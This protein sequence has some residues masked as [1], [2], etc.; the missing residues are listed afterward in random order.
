[1]W[2]WRKVRRARN[3]IQI[4]RKQWTNQNNQE[5]GKTIWSELG[6]VKNDNALVAT[7]VKL[8]AHIALVKRK[9]IQQH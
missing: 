8:V 1:M 2:K 9:I 6:R 4:V 7:E 3:R 5:K